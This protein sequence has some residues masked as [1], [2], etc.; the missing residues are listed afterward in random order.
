MWIYFP[1]LFS[2]G[3]NYSVRLMVFNECVKCSLFPDF[4]FFGLFT[5]M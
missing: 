2:E 4:Y 3:R 5:V 1:G